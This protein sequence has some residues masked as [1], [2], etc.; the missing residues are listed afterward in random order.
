[1]NFRSLNLF[2]VCT[3]KVRRRFFQILWPS[4]KTQTLLKYNIERLGD[5]NLDHQCLHLQ[6]LSQKCFFSLGINFYYPKADLAVT[7]AHTNRFIVKFRQ[8][9]LTTNLLDFIFI[10]YQLVNSG[11]GK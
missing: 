3:S 8:G 5:S 1:M 7:N 4:Q 9:V 11:F 10:L 6:S 2:K